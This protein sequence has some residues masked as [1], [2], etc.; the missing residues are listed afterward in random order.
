[1]LEYLVHLDPMDSPRDL[2]LV[3]AE[4]PDSVTRVVIAAERLPENCRETPAP[5]ELAAIGDR[6]A[7]RSRACIL[8]VPSALS[9]V[10]TN[11]LIDPQHP[12]FKRIR[13][14]V[15]ERLQYD[16]RLLKG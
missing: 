11:L 10:E 9:P 3:T 6:F 13:I 16:F 8:V 1:M 7:G 5:P 14:R 12:H 15:P 4:V 2:L